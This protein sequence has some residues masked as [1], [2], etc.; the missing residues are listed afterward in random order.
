KIKAVVKVDLLSAINSRDTV[1][2]SGHSCEIL[3]IVSV[4]LLIGSLPAVFIVFSGKVHTIGRLGIQR[5]FFL[6]IFGDGIYRFC[7]F[8]YTGGQVK[9]VPRIGSIKERMQFGIVP[10]SQTKEALFHAINFRN[11]L[12]PECHGDFM[13]SMINPKP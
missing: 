5:I 4:K 9:M 7:S 13:S 3:K 8:C 6:Y 11:S 1:K 2:G 10:L 12:L